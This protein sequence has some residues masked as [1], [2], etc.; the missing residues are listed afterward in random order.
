[1]IY[2]CIPIPIFSKLLKIWQHISLMNPKNHWPVKINL[3]R[4]KRMPI[5]LV[6]GGLQSCSRTFFLKKQSERPVTILYFSGFLLSILLTTMDQTIVRFGGL[7]FRLTESN[8]IR[9]L[10]R[11][12]GLYL[13]SIHSDKRHGWLQPV[14]NYQLYQILS[15]L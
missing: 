5:T 11:C 7:T 12:L 1:M 6:A 13:I 2:H 9:C 8:F 4:R 3:Q 10:R 14:R 15:F